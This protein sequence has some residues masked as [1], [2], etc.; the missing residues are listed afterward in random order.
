MNENKSNKGFLSELAAGDYGLP[1][2]FWMYGVLV[3]L[4]IQAI[5]ETV[6]IY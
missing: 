5:L 2:T 6:Y 4:I 3:F 1:K